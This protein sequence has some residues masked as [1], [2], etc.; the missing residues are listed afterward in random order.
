[1][2]TV[3]VL[4]ALAAAAWYGLS[5]IPVDFSYAV[6]AEFAEV[7]PDDHQLQEWL[8]TQPGVW[9][10]SV[11]RRP[12]GPRTRVV[13]LLGITRDG[14]RRPPFPDLDGKCAALGYRGPAGPFCDQEKP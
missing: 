5:L 1:M 13:V 3:V 14:W 4:V 6:E 8:R 9:H 11:Q 10:A 7:P 2:V 12:S